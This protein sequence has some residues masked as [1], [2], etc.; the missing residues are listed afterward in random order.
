MLDDSYTMVILFFITDGE[1][2]TMATGQTTAT[3][4]AFT[5]ARDRKIRAV[6]SFRSYLLLEC[7]ALANLETG[8]V[9]APA[10]TIVKGDREFFGGCD[11]PDAARCRK[12]SLETGVPVFCK[13]HTMRRLHQGLAVR[14]DG[15]I[16]R[17]KRKQF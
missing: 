8:D 3:T 1:T 17:A 14:I 4:K 7:G 12:T 2:K 13:H 11:C 6:N 9:Y 15:A 16:V 5:M 10:E